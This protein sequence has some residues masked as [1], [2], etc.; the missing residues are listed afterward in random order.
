[1]AV[2]TKWREGGGFKIGPGQE[3]EDVKVFTSEA[4]KN[5]TKS[6]VSIGG[7]SGSIQF[8]NLVASVE[9]RERFAKEIKEFIDKYGFDGVDLGELLIFLSHLHLDLHLPSPLYRPFA[10]LLTPCV[11]CRLGVPQL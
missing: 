4:K 8:G 7:W 11:P 5:K 1:V 10:A 3:E 6:L 9:N 2:T